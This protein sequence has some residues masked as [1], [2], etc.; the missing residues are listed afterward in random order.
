MK[1]VYIGLFFF[2]VTAT[3]GAQSDS[4]EAKVLHL[5]ELSGTEAMFVTSA[6]NMLDMQKES[7]AFASIPDEWWTEFEKRVRETAYK[8]LEPQLAKVYLDNYTEE[9]VDFLIDYHQ[10]PIAQG[11]MAKM[12]VV[13]QQSMQAGSAWGQKIAREIADQA[14][15]TPEGN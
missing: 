14:I 1:Q 9:E 10:N 6:M 4:L 15:V 13:Q 5:L 8:E 3:A 12:A 11:I 2:L 7:P